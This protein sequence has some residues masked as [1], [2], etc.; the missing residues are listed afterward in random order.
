MPSHTQTHIQKLSLGIILLAP[1]QHVA[2]IKDGL[3]V[4]SKSLNAL[5]IPEQQDVHSR[6]E[7]PSLRPRWNSKTKMAECILNEQ[8]LSIDGQ[9]S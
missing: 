8:T 9:V 2:E 1:L 4:K 3:L 6:S 5:M 7:H